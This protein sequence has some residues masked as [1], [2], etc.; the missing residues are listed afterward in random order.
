MISTILQILSLL[1]MFIAGYVV[2]GVW[3][4][5]QLYYQER[6][7]TAYVFKQEILNAKRLLAWDN[8]LRKMNIK[9]GHDNGMLVFPRTEKEINKPL[10]YKADWHEVIRLLPKN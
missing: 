5:W 6:R 4:Y 10:K 8:T 2:R 3:A 9:L 7:F 1:G